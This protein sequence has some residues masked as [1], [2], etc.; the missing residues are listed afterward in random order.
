MFTH[1]K[2]HKS[3]E[4]LINKMGICYVPHDIKIHKYKELLLLDS[5]IDD[6][7][8]LQKYASL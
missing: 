6:V 4:L 7:H 1:L 5:G 8:T 3:V 2:I